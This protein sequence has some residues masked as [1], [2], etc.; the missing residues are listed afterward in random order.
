[1]A[2]RAVEYTDSWWSFDEERWVEILLRYEDSQPFE[3]AMYQSTDDA[4]VLLCQF[5]RDLLAAGTG[6]YVGAGSVQIWPDLHS[7]SVYVSYAETTGDL[8]F[9]AP[10]PHVRDFVAESFR[11]VARREESWFL[12]VPDD[13]AELLEGSDDE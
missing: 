10:G 11:L 6:V 13:V 5:S 1:M 2:S 7:D 8:C 3:V 9:L 4:D 12:A